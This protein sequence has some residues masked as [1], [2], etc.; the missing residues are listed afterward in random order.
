MNQRDKIVN[1]FSDAYLVALLEG[2]NRSEVVI[3]FSKDFPEMSSEFEANAISLNLLYGD[4]ATA[5]KPLDN[6][7]AEVY[8]KVSERFGTSPAH[9]VVTAIRSGFYNEMRTFFSASP[10]WAGATLG[11]GAAVLIALFW[12]PWVINESIRGTANNGIST[13]NASNKGSR[14]SANDQVSKDPMKLPEVR[15]RGKSTKEML[16]ASQKRTQ[17]SIDAI[18]LK[19][20]SALKPLSAPLN[21]QIEAQRVAGEIMI[22]WNASPDALSYIIEM[23]GA[24]DDSYV[25]VTQISQTGAR[26]TSLESGKTYLVRVIA[27]SGERVGP[28]SDAKSIVVP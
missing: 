24:N 12:Q 6:D 5:P 1:N 3:Q 7:I 21:L 27:A 15:Y 2:V 10:M 14:F 25:P 28:A 11:I 18:H 16:T 22:R 23:K 19:Q 9:K 4:L 8:K 13:E 26:I 20:M 17:D